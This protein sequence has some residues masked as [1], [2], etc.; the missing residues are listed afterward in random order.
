MKRILIA[1]DNAIVRRGLRGLI[2]HHQDWDVCGEAANG[3][4]AI[5]QARVLHPDLLLLDLAMPGM[6]GFDAAQ[7]LAKVEPEVQILLCTIQLSS[8]VVREAEKRGIHG[9]V[10]KSNVSEITDGIAAL[11]RHEKFYCCPVD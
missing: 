1:D 9:A 2:Q 5:E 7:E 4:D 10:S 11:L 8:Y 6:N 3:R